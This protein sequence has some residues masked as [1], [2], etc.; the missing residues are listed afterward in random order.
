MTIIDPPPPVNPPMRRRYSRHA[1][2]AIAE[3]YAALCEV[4][5][6]LRKVADVN[7]ARDGP[8]GR[9]PPDLGGD[10]ARPEETRLH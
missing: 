4:V 3:A 10:E 6:R 5:M 2:R 8:E 7:V 1:N 9:V